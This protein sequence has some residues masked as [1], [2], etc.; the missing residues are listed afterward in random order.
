MK[1]LSIKDNYIYKKLR[2]G[3]DAA[4]KAFTEGKEAGLRIAQRT[5][6]GGVTG[7][8]YK[9][10]SYGPG[11]YEEVP[12]DVDGNYRGPTIP[13]PDPT[14]PF[15]WAHHNPDQPDNILN[16]I[17]YTP[18]GEMWGVHLP[19]E[20]PRKLKPAD[21]EK[22]KQEQLKHQQSLMISDTRNLQKGPVPR[23]TPVD[24]ALSG[25]KRDG[26]IQNQVDPLRRGVKAYQQQQRGYV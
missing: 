5:N 24:E 25:Y 7:A 15:D 17:L 4:D 23:L 8:E 18:D 22:I 6:T 10:P 11:G 12:F 1:G 13:N 19:G 2:E 14:Q 16:H 26:T 3:Q 9:I 21:L 20:E